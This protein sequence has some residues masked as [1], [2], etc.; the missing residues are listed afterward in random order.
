MGSWEAIKMDPNSGLSDKILPDGQDAKPQAKHL[1]NRADYL[2]KVMAK[3]SETQQFGKPVKQKRQ[4][5][6]KPIS[7]TFIGETED[8]SSG[9]DFTLI[10]PPPSNP[11]PRRSSSSKAPKA[12]KVKTE[13]EDSHIEART[14]DE[15]A[16]VEVKERKKEAS[17]K[18]E[19]KAKKKDAGPMHF[20][21][22]SVPRAVEIIGDLDPAIFNEVSSKNLA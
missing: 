11:P 18:K 9:E 12:A 15:R 17:V 20:T 10:N 7:K 19:K 1:Q 22:N 4:R 21:A 13:D 8:I 2:L 5:K 16:P 6:A 14:E 3:L